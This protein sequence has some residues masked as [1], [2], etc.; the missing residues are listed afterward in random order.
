MR[1][2]ASVILILIVVFSLPAQENA[3]D[4]LTI[5]I[6]I[7][8]SG[9]EVYSWFGHNALIIENTNSGQSRFYNYGLFS[10]ENENFFIN[11][12]M[13]RMLYSSGVIS[14]DDGIADYISQNR[15][16]VL[17]TLNLPA[18]KR[19]RVLDF[20]ETSILPEN[21][22]YL[23]H[24]FYDNCS[25][26][27]RDII[28]IATGGQFKKQLAETPGRF[29]FRQHVRL[30]IGFSP[31]WD[32]ALNFLMGQ[33]VDQPIS[34]WD[35]MFL[36]SEVAKQIISFSY[37]D[38]SGKYNELVSNIETIYISH[39][40]PVIPIAPKRN[41]PTMLI[42]SL[43]IFIIIGLLFLLQS[44]EPAIGQIMIGVENSILG[45][46]FGLAGLLLF[47]ISFFTNH[48]YTFHNANL[49]FCNPIL[50]MTVPLGIKYAS[51]D[52]YSERLFAEISLRMIWFLM[53][54][55]VFISFFIRQCNLSIK[56]LILPISIILSLEPIGLKKL[57]AHLFWRWQ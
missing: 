40:R 4:E 21:R 20:A 13:G 23:Y 7:L 14:T 54:I 52:N 43:I 11:F 35:E 45:L 1:V 48:D 51:A 19:K 18:E 16:V 42:Y 9:D 50:I 26:R 47:F 28:D 44:R 6:A 46:C 49:L 24:I 8:G 15:D 27:I 29:T 41:W 10:F 2:A 32:L 56:V 57:L 53:L 33:N 34:V 39:N 3:G 36:P 55:G 12:V 17:Y 5:K 30:H 37:I 22:D 31:F 25:T 38:E